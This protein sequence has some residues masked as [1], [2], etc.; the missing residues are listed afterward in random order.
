MP[1]NMLMESP[2]SL[3]WTVSS[4]SVQLVFAPGKPRML[5]AATLLRQLNSPIKAYPATSPSLVPIRKTHSIDFRLEPKSRRSSATGCSKERSY[6]V[7]K[8]QL[9]GTPMLMILGKLLSLGELNM[10]TRNNEIAMS[11]R[12]NRLPMATYLSSI[13]TN[14]ETMITLVSME[15]PR[16]SLSLTTS[17]G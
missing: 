7:L 2:D 13:L 6:G 12:W 10:K 3:T 15:R 8:T 16:G 9:N 1:I 14:I 17:Q 5:L 11:V 4:T